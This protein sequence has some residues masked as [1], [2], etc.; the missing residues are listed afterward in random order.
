M[1]ACSDEN[2]L[3]IRKFIENPPAVQQAALAE[4]I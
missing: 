2:P 4:L 3:F 1:A